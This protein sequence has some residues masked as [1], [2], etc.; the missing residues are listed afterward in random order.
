MCKQVLLAAKISDL[1]VPVTVTGMTLMLACKKC[2][3]LGVGCF[4]VVFSARVRRVDIGA[5]ADSE[6]LALKII[7]ASDPEIDIPS[8]Y[9]S[10]NSFSNAGE[11]QRKPGA[12][13]AK[14]P[15]PS[16]RGQAPVLLLQ[17]RSLDVEYSY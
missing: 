5:V 14:A 2:S 16:Q 15:E 13:A 4:G 11:A 1:S 6:N 17:V 9:F 7:L 8:E 10:S 3:I 12:V